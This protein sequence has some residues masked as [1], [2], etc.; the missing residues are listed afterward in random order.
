MGH[1]TVTFKKNS[2]T[3]AWLKE[4]AHLQAISE[5]L[6]FLWVQLDDFHA[7]AQIQEKALM[8][9]QIQG[10]EHLI[11]P[12]QFFKLYQSIKDLL[13]DN[14]KIGNFL[15]E[16]YTIP[17]YFIE[18]ENDMNRRGKNGSGANFHKDYVSNWVVNK[19]SG[20]VIEIIPRT[21]KDMLLDYYH[22]KK[23]F[24][25]RVNR[26]ISKP[27]YFTKSF[28]QSQLKYQNI[29]QQMQQSFQ[30]SNENSPRVLQFTPQ[31]MLQKQTSSV[32]KNEDIIKL[33]IQQPEVEQK[34]VVKICLGVWINSTIDSQF[35]AFI[36]NEPRVLLQV[37]P[38]LQGC[39]GNM[40]GFMDY[41]GLVRYIQFHFAVKQYQQNQQNPQGNHV[42]QNAEDVTNAIYKQMVEIVFISLAQ[43]I[44]YLKKNPKFSQLLDFQFT[45]DENLKVYL[46][47]IKDTMKLDSS[48]KK[49]FNEWKL[50]M[51]SE[52]FKKIEERLKHM[53]LNKMSLPGIVKNAGQGNT[54]L[55]KQNL[56]STQNIS[57]EVEGFKITQDQ[58]NQNASMEDT[59]DSLSFLNEFEDSNNKNTQ[60]KNDKFKMNK[61]KS[62][63]QMPILEKQDDQQ[64]INADILR[65]FSTTKKS[66]PT[67]YYYKQRNLPLM[68]FLFSSKRMQD[69][70]QAKETEDRRNG[71]ITEEEQKTQDAQ[72]TNISDI[73]ASQIS[74]LQK[75]ED[76]IMK[77]D[78]FEEQKQR[79]LLIKELNKLFGK[80]LYKNAANELQD[81]LMGKADDEFKKLD[82]KDT[83]KKNEMAYEDAFKSRQQHKVYNL[84]YFLDKNSYFNK[85]KEQ[86]QALYK[87][88]KDPQKFQVHLESMG[89]TENKFQYN[90]KQGFNSARYE[91]T[92]KTQNS[93]IEGKLIGLKKQAD[94]NKAQDKMNLLIKD[95]E[96]GP[97]LPQI[98]TS[99]ESTHKG[100]LLLKNKSTGR[101]LN[102]ATS[103]RGDT[104]HDVAIDPRKYAE[105]IN[106]QHLVDK[107]NLQSNNKQVQIAN[108]KF[109][110]L[111]QRIDTIYDQFA[112]PTS[113]SKAKKMSLQSPI[114]KKNE[115]G[116]KTGATPRN[117]V[118]IFG[119]TLPPIQLRHGLSV[120]QVP[121]LQKQAI[122]SPMLSSSLKAHDKLSR[123]ARLTKNHT[124]EVSNF[125]NNQQIK[126][127][128]S[129]LI[130]SD[131]LQDDANSIS[132]WHLDESAFIKEEDQSRDP[133]IVR[134]STLKDQSSP[135]QANKRAQ[136]ISFSNQVQVLDMSP[137]LKNQQQANMTPRQKKYLQNN[138]L[139]IQQQQQQQQLII[140]NLEKY[141]QKQIL[142]DMKQMLDEFNK[143]NTTNC[144]TVQLIPLIPFNSESKRLV[145]MLQKVSME[146]DQKMFVDNY[147]QI[148]E[149][150]RRNY[151]FK[152]ILKRFN[153]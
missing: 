102:N 153:Q 122:S 52:V 10:I 27:F 49:L 120:L 6:D 67:F 85:S 106:F 2:S 24:P 60:S 70:R 144:A 57:E 90:A 3:S 111:V 99:R 13:P 97:D 142:R 38:L 83:K 123:N 124:I 53:R 91:N 61:S 148:V 137:T 22:Y 26:N 8:I 145:G 51:M 5:P 43:I 25:C 100:K 139:Q 71:F 89:L 30:S 36:F 150:F 21:S 33:Q 119:K 109:V 88:I 86:V 39:K 56:Q 84:D 40:N 75:L 152:K 134:K 66:L 64:G 48:D 110:G 16:S 28:A 79:F 72:A 115:Y 44:P 130:S 62:V 9:N 45:L 41:K 11:D 55:A 127:G 54:T 29:A 96:K 133:L 1:A 37:E 101:L 46:Y 103:L 104:L 23:H 151:E 135:P 7:G 105:R 112:L 95:I 116:L 58:S 136:Q 140:D 128:F 114:I 17:K 12:D 92:N 69:I 87:A 73:S 131:N 15:L 42:I 78:K 76:Y 80:D 74:Q 32:K 126:G 143:N 77:S 34:F 117:T 149:E 65:F 146:I 31:I 98:K 107:M 125:P 147:L 63:A 4:T 59:D 108:E 132:K 94:M 121:D 19:G 81:I 82:D 113:P 50:R 14:F 18:L 20:N 118:N 129:K 47:R 141:S 138:K 35:E 68:H 93:G